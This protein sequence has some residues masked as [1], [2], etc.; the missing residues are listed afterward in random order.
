M[1]ELEVVVLRS[2]LE[3]TGATSKP[4]QNSVAQNERDR[5]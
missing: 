5:I 4:A 2:G 1:Q 3:R